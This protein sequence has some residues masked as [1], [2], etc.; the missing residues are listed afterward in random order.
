MIRQKKRLITIMQKRIEL[1]KNKSNKNK[2]V[3]KKIKQLKRM[4]KK[5]FNSPRMILKKLNKI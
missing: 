3:L 1:E 5:T 2:E 4:R